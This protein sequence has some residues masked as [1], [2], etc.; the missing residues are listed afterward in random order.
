MAVGA[1]EQ[2]LEELPSED[3]DYKVDAVIINTQIFRK[4]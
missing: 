1:Q 3:H 2:L 4:Q